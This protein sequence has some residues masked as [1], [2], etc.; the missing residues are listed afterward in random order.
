MIFSF[1]KCWT[2]KENNK[3]QS[4]VGLHTHH[5]WCN[6]HWCLPKLSHFW[7]R[8]APNGAENRMPNSEFQCRM[9]TDKSMNMNVYFAA[10]TSVTHE[11]IA[12]TPTEL[13]TANFERLFLWGRLHNKKWNTH[14]NMRALFI[15]I[16]PK[17]CIMHMP[18]CTHAH[19]V[20]KYKVYT[21]SYQKF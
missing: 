5:F 15:L 17:H 14:E 9:S 18:T 6:T 2:F 20:L 19:N 7:R 1:N 16:S 13:W 3:N 12:V 4:C 21:M 11:G 8:A 10:S